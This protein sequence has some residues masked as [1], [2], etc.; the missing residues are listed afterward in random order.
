MEKNNP[1][2]LYEFKKEI[3]HDN[4]GNVYSVVTE[5]YNFWGTE[6]YETTKVTKQRVSKEFIEKELE[7]IPE[8][9]ASYDMEISRSEELIKRMKDEINDIINTRDYLDFKHNFEKN[10]A[11][12]KHLGT[13][14]KEKKLEAEQTKLDTLNKNLNITKESKEH[15]EQLLNKLDS[16]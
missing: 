12:K 10:P 1:K 3:E 15:Y 5:Q 13:I 2:D 4:N 9:I 11:F 6:G 16:N 14:S 8:E 7:H